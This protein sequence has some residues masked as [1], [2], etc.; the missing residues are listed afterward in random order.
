MWWVQ[1]ELSKENWEMHG[2]GYLR[3]K[4]KDNPVGMTQMQIDTVS[5][6]KVCSTETYWNMINPVIPKYFW[7]CKFFFK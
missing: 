3:R 2:F 7:S 1:N 6:K 4:G 5:K